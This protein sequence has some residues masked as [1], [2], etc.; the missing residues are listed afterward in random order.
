MLAADSVCLGNAGN[1][2]LYYSVSHLGRPQTISRV[3]ESRMLRGINGPKVQ[4]LASEWRTLY[5]EGLH[6]LY[7]SPI[8]S[9]SSQMQHVKMSGIWSIRVRYEKC[10]EDFSRNPERETIV[11][12]LDEIVG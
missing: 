8:I 5:N 12:N 7:S 1:H 9:K 11:I 2:L 6:E 4:L 3:L 10:M